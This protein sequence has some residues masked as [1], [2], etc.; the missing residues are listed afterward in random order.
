VGEVPGQGAGGAGRNWYFPH[1]P[2]AAP[3]E[4]IDI[5]INTRYI[6]NRRSLKSKTPLQAPFGSLPAGIKQ[7]S[8]NSA[9]N[10]SAAARTAER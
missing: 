8:A 3:Q 6:H 2:S 4:T 1:A 5:L 9:F 10:K 7:K